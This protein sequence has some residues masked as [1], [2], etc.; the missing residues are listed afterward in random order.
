[1]CHQERTRGRWKQNGPNVAK[2]LDATNGISPHP[3]R[4][5]LPNRIW[6]LQNTA[7]ANIWF[8]HFHEYLG[9]RHPGRRNQCQIHYILKIAN[10]LV[11]T[12]VCDFLGSRIPPVDVLKN[13]FPH[14]RETLEALLPTSPPLFFTNNF[15]PGL[16]W[17]PRRLPC[18]GDRGFWCPQSLITSC[19][20]YIPACLLGGSGQNAMNA[21]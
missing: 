20:K 14:L 8:R 17:T 12:N 21:M 15:L 13:S 6:D 2:H 3:S 5:C 4:C 19:H 9:G 18:W 7:Q 10:T 1:M 11:V 16:P